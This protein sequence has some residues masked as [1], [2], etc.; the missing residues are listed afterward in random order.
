MSIYDKE[1][2]VLNFV[3]EKEINLYDSDE[4]GKTCQK[5]LVNGREV[6]IHEFKR[7]KK[8]QERAKGHNWVKRHGFISD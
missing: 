1:R 5:I 6:S 2:E 8:K 4:A 7:N 3:Y